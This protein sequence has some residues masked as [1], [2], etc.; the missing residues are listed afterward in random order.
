MSRLP[1]RIVM[2]LGVTLLAALALFSY[3]APAL[4]QGSSEPS[5]RHT[6]VQSSEATVGVWEY[7]R[8]VIAVDDTPGREHI[9]VLGVGHPTLPPTFHCAPV[10]DTPPPI[11]TIPSNRG[12]PNIA[13]RNTAPDEES[14]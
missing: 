9:C 12:E 10:R 4:P 1:K 7:P 5:Y 13:P 2:Y 6:P 14:L 11:I 3:T 8:G